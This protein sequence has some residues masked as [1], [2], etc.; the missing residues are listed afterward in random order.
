VHTL[1]H[2]TWKSALSW[3]H[4]H[5]IPRHI[6]ILGSENCEA[7]A[8]IGKNMPQPAVN[9]MLSSAKNSDTVVKKQKQTVYCRH[10]ILTGY[11]YK[12]PH[13]KMDTGVFY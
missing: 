4:L 5:L 11:R 8:K 10:Y 13:I 6:R 2:A 3:I 7:L 12:Q 9:M 1:I